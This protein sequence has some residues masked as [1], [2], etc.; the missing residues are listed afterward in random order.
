MNWLRN[1]RRNNVQADNTKRFSYNSQRFYEE[2][3]RCLLPTRQPILQALL[4]FQPAY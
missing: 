1:A 2:L 4:L 3:I